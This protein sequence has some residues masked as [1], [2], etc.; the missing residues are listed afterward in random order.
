MCWPPLSVAALYPLPPDSYLTPFPSMCYTVRYTHTLLAAQ[1]LTKQNKVWT[2]ATEEC[3]VRRPWGLFSSLS[4]CEAILYS[5]TA[6]SCTFLNNP[7]EPLSSMAS[8]YQEAEFLQACKQ[9]RSRMVF[10]NL[11]PSIYL[12]VACSHKDPLFPISSVTV[13]LNSFSCLLCFTQCCPVVFP[14]F[15]NCWADGPRIP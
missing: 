15:G 6:S 1:T 8:E 4:L 12:L 10:I 9:G 3:A 13:I 5:E 14:K 11:S 7:P 2:F